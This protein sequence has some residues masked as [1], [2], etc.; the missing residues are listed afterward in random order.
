MKILYAVQATGN[1]HIS[2]AHQLYPYLKA[3][4]EVDIIL[5]GSNA[6]LEMDIP[7]KYRSKGASL[8]YTRCGGLDYWKSFKEFNLTA[9][10]KDARDLPVEK[11]DLV[12]N[13]FDHITA[14]ACKLKNVPS[15][16]LGH[17]ASFMSE[18]APR[19][20]KRSWV[21]ETV[22]KK[23]APSDHYVGFHF[24]RYDSF[25]FPPVIKQSIIDAKPEDHGH[26]TVYTPAYR[27]EC[28]EN[29][30]RSLD[31]LDI[32]WFLNTVEKPYRDGNIHFLPISQKYF[33]ES[34]IHCRGLVTGGGFETPAEAL[35][36]GKKLLT[37]PIDGQYE[38]QCNA[39]ALVNKG[40]AR[41]SF[42]NEQTASI[43]HKWLED[44]SP[45]PYQEAAIINEVLDYVLSL[46]STK[47]LI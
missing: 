11:Y 23:Y 44:K 40:I 32:H 9:I 38:Q 7:V 45:T 10:N 35:Y 19:P 26:I 43:L 36:L 24:D 47:Q 21:G 1:G 39:Q 4:G 42:L 33:T 16:Q 25:I 14:R 30:W 37:I 6:T 13:D 3:L 34:M 41:L 31:H 15:I 46:Q 8:F 27:T 17:Q 20:A 5:S 29:I 28:H 2:R 12:I 18:K 22:L